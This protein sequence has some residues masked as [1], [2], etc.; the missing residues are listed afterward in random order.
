M[1]IISKESVVLR[2]CYRYCCIEV[3]LNFKLD[4][5]W[6]REYFIIYFTFLENVTV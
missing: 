1:G 3:K 6:H 4:F 5:F 2:Y